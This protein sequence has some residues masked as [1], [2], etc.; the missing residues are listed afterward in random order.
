MIF[1]ICILCRNE[2]DPIVIENAA[3]SAIEEE[4]LALLEEIVMHAFQQVV[5]YLTKVI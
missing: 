3:T 4:I 1:H 2:V 5:Y